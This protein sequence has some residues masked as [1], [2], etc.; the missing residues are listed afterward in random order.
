MASS[1]ERE[2]LKEEY[3]EHFRKL[4]EAKQKVSDSL[5]VNRIQAALNDMGVG[6]LMDSMGDMIDTVKEKIAIAEARIDI[7]LES[8]SEDQELAKAD[9]ELKDIDASKKARDTIQ[10]IK[11]EMGQ[12]QE[13][14]EKEAANIRT[15]KTMGKTTA[16]PTLS[17]SSS[18]TERRP[19][20]A[21]KTIGKK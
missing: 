2:R 3:K 13:E 12:I 1:E 14:L 5:K 10:K 9:E 4:R 21:N 17:D 8:Y 7:A 18:E 15:E 11:M 19:I 6:D 16:S 20:T